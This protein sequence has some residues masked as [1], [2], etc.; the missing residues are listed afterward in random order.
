[1]ALGRQAPLRSATATPHVTTSGP[2]TVQHG[3]YKLFYTIYYKC[4]KALDHELRL[5][6]VTHSVLLADGFC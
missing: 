5:R 2:R 3:V 4:S 1:M 6:D